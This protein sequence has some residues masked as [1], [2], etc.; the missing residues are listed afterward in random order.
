MEDFGTS[1]KGC[2]PHESKEFYRWRKA[3][4]NKAFEASR[5]TLCLERQV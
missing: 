5:S 4:V 3:N 2:K 1:V